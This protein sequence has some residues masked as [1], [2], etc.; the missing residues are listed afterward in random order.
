MAEYNAHCKQ[1]SSFILWETEALF[2]TNDVVL[3]TINAISVAFD[4]LINLLIAI[5]MKKKD[6]IKTPCHIL[7]FSLT[8]IDLVAALVPKPLYI[9]LRLAIYREHVTSCSLN[10]KARVTESAIIFCVGCSFLHLVCIA[11]DRCNALCHP[12]RYRTPGKMKGEH[13]NQKTC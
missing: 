12:V 10:R 6:L 9:D 4:I 1:L 13:H 11:R 8:A 7:V 2:K 5:V 3:C